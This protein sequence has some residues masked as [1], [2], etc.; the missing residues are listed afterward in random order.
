MLSGDLPVYDSD[1]H[2]APVSY[3]WGTGENQRVLSEIIDGELH[4]GGKWGC[5][6]VSCIGVSYMDNPETNRLLEAR[7]RR[8]RRD[9]M[10]TLGLFTGGSG[11]VIGATGGVVPASLFYTDI[12]VSLAQAG[13]AYSIGGAEHL[14][15]N[16]VGFLGGKTSS[17]AAKG[18]S[19]HNVFPP[20][21]D[22]YVP[23][24]FDGALKSIEER[25]N[26]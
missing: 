14:L 20:V 9:Y 7:D 18:A 11:I 22:F 24:A 25:E 12:G 6:N 23:K 13:N 3:G 2:N 17:F 19:F 1:S 26:D 5:Y 10:T 8:A 16:L 21:L 15:P 4:T